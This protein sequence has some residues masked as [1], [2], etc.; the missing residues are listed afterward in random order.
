M[1]VG[2]VDVFGVVLMNS[3]VGKEQV[4]VAVAALISKQRETY[5]P[6]TCSNLALLHNITVFCGDVSVLGWKDTCSVYTVWIY[7]TVF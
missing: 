5:K 4:T 7:R 2:Q 1:L 3:R 6:I